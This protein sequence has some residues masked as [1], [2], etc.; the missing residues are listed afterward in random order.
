[1]ARS[2]GPWVA[3]VG[4]PGQPLRPDTTRGHDAAQWF[5]ELNGLPAV[6]A[7]HR[8]IVDGEVVAFGEHGRPDFGQLRHRMH[9][10]RAAEIARVAAR[11]PA[12]DVIFDLLWLDDRDLTGL[13][14]LKRR[15]LLADVVVPGDGWLVGSRS[16]RGWCGRPSQGGQGT[17]ARRDRDA[18]G[19]QQF[20]TLLG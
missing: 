6:L 12:R 1:M 13:P 19:G 18:A 11:I 5:P 17:A 20:A 9:L 14:Y 3:A 4:D 16:S 15:E 7:P 2:V 8:L 10:T